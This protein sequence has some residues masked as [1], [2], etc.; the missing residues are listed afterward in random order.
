MFY[1]S[2]KHTKHKIKT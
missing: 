1:P 2:V